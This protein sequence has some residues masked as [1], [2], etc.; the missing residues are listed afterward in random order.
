MPF[1][2]FCISVDMLRKR[3]T[4]TTDGVAEAKSTTTEQTKPTSKSRS[5]LFTIIFLFVFIVYVVIPLS[6]YTCPAVRRHAVFLNYVSLS[7]QKN[8]SLP[9]ESGLKCTKN[10]YIKTGE[11]IKVGV[12]HVPPQSALP[13]CK[14]DV[15][16]ETEAFKDLRPIFLYLHGNAGTRAGGH[17]VELYKL[18]SEKVDAHVMAFDYRGFGDSTNVSPTEGGLVEDTVQVY[19]WLLKRA[20]ASRI[21]VWGHSLGTGVGVAFLEKLS[22]SPVKPAS[23]ILEAPFT[24]IIDAARHHPLSIFHRYMPFFDT[25]IAQPIGDKETGFNSID[26]INEVQCPLLILHAEDDGFVPFDHGKKLY[27][28]AVVARKSLPPHQT[29]FVGFDGKYDLGHKNIYLSPDLPNIIKTFIKSVDP[30]LV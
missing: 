26:R 20:N 11:N 12:W 15:L 5:F 28:E 25:L 7:R 21:F 18:L 13:K 1:K 19:N 4:S 17:R 8:L 30:T 16:P 22:K 27:E 10:L 2:F 6:V 23:L 3:Q 14:G 24:R 29:Q 9:S